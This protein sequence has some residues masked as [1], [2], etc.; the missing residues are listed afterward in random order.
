VDTSLPV[1]ADA[2]DNEGAFC[3]LRADRQGGNSAD[4]FA[5]VDFD[6]H[7]DNLDVSA[8]LKDLSDGQQ[9]A[10]LRHELG[11]AA[12]GL[13]HNDMCDSL[14]MPTWR[15]CR[16]NDTLRRTTVGPHDVAD[17]Y[18]YWNGETPLYPIRNECWTN[19]TPAATACAT[20]LAADQ[21][22]PAGLPQAMRSE[23]VGATPVRAPSNPV[24]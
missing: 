2:T 15:L 19:E 11:H 7:P 18:T 21:R 4:Y 17:R 12:L 9:G 8:R 5:R 24:E 6:A 10:T 14:V 3:E 23:G 20:G 13:A 16:N 22:P 1:I